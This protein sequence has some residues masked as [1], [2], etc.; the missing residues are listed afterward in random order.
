MKANVKSNNTNKRMEGLRRRTNNDELVSNI[1]EP[2]IPLSQ[3]PDKKAVKLRNSNWLSQLDGRRTQSY[4]I[5]ASK[6]DKRTR[7]G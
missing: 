2:V 3:F 7:E 4:R 5:N 6:H 1:N